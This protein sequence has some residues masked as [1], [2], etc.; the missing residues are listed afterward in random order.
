VA[1]NRYRYKIKAEQL[2][3][4]QKGNLVEARGPHTAS[5]EGVFGKPPQQTTGLPALLGY[6]EPDISVIIVKPNN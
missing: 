1:G 4:D 5:V 2:V 3:V 6:S